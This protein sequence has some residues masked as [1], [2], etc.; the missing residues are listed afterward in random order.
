MNAG[1]L[2]A[3]HVSTQAITRAKF[4]ARF[5]PAHLIRKICGQRLLEQT[6]TTVTPNITTL[7]P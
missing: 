6:V 1:I 4:F 7:N 2:N 3:V 5:S